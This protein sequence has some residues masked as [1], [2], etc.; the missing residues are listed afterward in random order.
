VGCL[1]SS[2]VHRALDRAGERGLADL[3][4]DRRAA[5]VAGQRERQHVVTVLQGGQDELPGAPRVEEAV[6]ADE[7][8][9]GA[10]AVRWRER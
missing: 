4:L 8:R 5:R 9:P 7:R 1:E 6:Q 10:P 2:L 3:S